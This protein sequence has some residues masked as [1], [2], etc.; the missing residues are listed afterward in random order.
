MQ[1][2]GTGT[3]GSTNRQALLVLPGIGYGPSGMRAMRKFHA[4]FA[5]LD[6]FVPN[7]IRKAGLS[8]S[9]VA[10]SH[11]IQEQ[12]LERY[13]TVHVFCFIAGAYIF[14]DLMQSAPLQNAGYLMLDR[15]PY[16]ER[17]PR[18]V[19]KRIPWIARA[20]LGDFVFE[21]ASRNYPDFQV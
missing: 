6:L 7:Y 13:D 2:L 18:I 17:A 20:L 11:Y 10:A 16:Q 12:R 5:G 19:T 15:S 3:D 4:S 8:A 9:M 1:L 14:H 21:L